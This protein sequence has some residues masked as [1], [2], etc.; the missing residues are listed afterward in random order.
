MS[1]LPDNF[2]TRAFEATIG[3]RMSVPEQIL[4]AHTDHLRD[5]VNR[6]YREFPRADFG[7]ARER[8]LMIGVALDRA[9]KALNTVTTL[10][11][12][13]E[14][15]LLCEQER[16]MDSDTEGFKAAVIQAIEDWLFVYEKAIKREAA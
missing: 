16:A 9:S 4:G 2:N 8:W 12:H 10:S 15:A 3:S 1:N 11:V 6:A 14:R 13:D 5:I 7:H